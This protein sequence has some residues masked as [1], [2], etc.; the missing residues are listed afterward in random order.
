M[1]ALGHILAVSAISGLLA[2]QSLPSLAQGAQGGETGIESPGAATGQGPE[3]S[4]LQASVAQ[5]GAGTNSGA[6]TGYSGPQPESSGTPGEINVPPLP[7][8]SLCDDYRDTP[9]HQSCLLVVLRQ[10]RS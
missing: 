2:L 1:K 9:A 7:A 6:T 8:A 10:T 5:V 4:G 3:D